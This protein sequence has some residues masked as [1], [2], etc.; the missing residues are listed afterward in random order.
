MFLS[1]RTN[2]LGT[3]LSKATS[4]GQTTHL[5][6]FPCGSVMGFILD[7]PSDI[8]QQSPGPLGVSGG[9][10]FPPGRCCPTLLL[11]LRVPLPAN[12]DPTVKP[13]SPPRPPP[14]MGTWILRNGARITA[15]D[16]PCPGQSIDGSKIRFWS[17]GKQIPTTFCTYT[18]YSPHTRY[19]SPTPFSIFLQNTPEMHKLGGED[20]LYSK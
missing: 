13:H 12:R 17:K 3:L 19:T 16:I 11:P 1:E 10:C 5:D 14:A 7:A 18:V 2:S 4:W 9:G 8:H 6:G 15:L 20:A